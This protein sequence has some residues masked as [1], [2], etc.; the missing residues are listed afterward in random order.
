MLTC[1]INIYSASVH[2]SPHAQAMP[3]IRRFDRYPTDI[4]RGKIGFYT[5]IRCIRVVVMFIRMVAL[6]QLESVEPLPCMIAVELG[7]VPTFG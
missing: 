1:T 3:A 2:G 6:C 7:I 5:E 4:A